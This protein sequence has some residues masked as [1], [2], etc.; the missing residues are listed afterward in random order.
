MGVPDSEKPDIIQPA[1][2]YRSFMIHKKSVSQKRKWVGD[3]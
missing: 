1:L 2:G 3:E